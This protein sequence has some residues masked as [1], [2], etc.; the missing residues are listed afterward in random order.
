M[1]ALETSSGSSST[2]GI[3]IPKSEQE[4]AARS[5]FLKM[6]PSSIPLRTEISMIMTETHSYPGMV[7]GS[8]ARPEPPMS[9]PFLELPQGTKLG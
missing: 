6:G 1:R 9:L 8:K 4:V 2:A 7:K 5:H 3:R